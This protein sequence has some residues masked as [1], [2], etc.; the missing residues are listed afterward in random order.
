MFIMNYDLICK[1]PNELIYKILDYHPL[2]YKYKR[3]YYKLFIYNNQIYNSIPLTLTEYKVL[4]KD[5]TDILIENGIITKAVIFK[6][7][8]NF[9]TH[10]SNGLSGLDYQP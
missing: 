5:I 3:Q 4:E 7:V 6:L 8:S 10:G 2:F 1:L 9:N